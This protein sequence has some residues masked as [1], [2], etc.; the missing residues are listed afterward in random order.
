MIKNSIHNE[1]VERIKIKYL[2][3]ETSEAESI[4]LMD[5]LENSMQMRRELNILAAGLKSFYYS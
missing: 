3:G 5:E 4:I 2:E 1:T